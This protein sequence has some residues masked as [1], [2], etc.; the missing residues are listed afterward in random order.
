[1]L[2]SERVRGELTR[3]VGMPCWAVAVWRTAS[4]VRRSLNAIASNSWW[5][6]SGVREDQLVMSERTAEREDVLI[7]DSVW[8]C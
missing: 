5:L 6:V 8:M 3:Q 1:M 4:P 7:L 2:A